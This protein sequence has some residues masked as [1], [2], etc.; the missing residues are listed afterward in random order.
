MQ[1]V[2]EKLING[3]PPSSIKSNI[4]SFVALTNPS[5]KIKELPGL[6]LI[7]ECCAAIQIIGETLTAYRI[8]NAEKWEQVFTDGTSR[9][10]IALQNLVVGL[11]NDGVM[12]PLILSSAIISENETSEKQVEAII[13]KVSILLMDFKQTLLLYQHTIGDQI[14][15][16]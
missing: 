12:K 6:S 7:R 13:L 8:A 3:T 14:K 2:I 1:L 10:Q 4:A 5:Y 11:L 15:S 16:F 9:R